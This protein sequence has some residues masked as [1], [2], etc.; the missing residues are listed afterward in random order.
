MHASGSILG[1][2]G[3]VLLHFIWQGALVAALVAAGLWL[4][5]GRGAHERYALACGGL[6][7]MVAAPLVTAA[8]LVGPMLTAPA[9]PA[10][11]GGGPGVPAASPLEAALPLITTLWLVGTIGFQA[12]LLLLWGRAERLRRAGTGPIPATLAPIVADLVARIGVRRPVRVVQSSL[13]MVPTVV[14]WLRPVVLVPAAALTGLGPDQLR[15]VIA[16]ELAH[17]RRHDYLVNVLQ[18]VCEALLFYH[19]AVWWISG[20]IRA[21]REYCC[22]DVAVAVCGNA[23]L[24]ARAL[25]TLDEWRSTD[26]WPALAST[27]EPLMKRICR[28][29]GVRDARSR[30]PVSLMATVTLVMSAAAVAAV[31]SLHPADE[32]DH[33]PPAVAGDPLEGIDVVRIAVAMAAEDAETFELLRDLGL[34]NA[35]L[36]RV[37]KALGTDEKVFRAVHHLAK[38]RARVKAEVMK[39]H[40]ELALQVAEGTMSRAELEEKVKHLTERARRHMAEVQK[41]LVA[42]HAVDEASGPVAHLRQ[43]AVELEAAGQRLQAMHA[44]VARALEAGEISPEQARQH[45]AEI[46]QKRADLAAAH[47]KLQLEREKLHDHV[48]EL[49]D[50]GLTDEEIHEALARETR[51]RP[52]RKLEE[53]RLALEEKLATLHVRADT[54]RADIH[55]ALRAGK[56]DEAEARQKMER[57]EAEIEHAR[58]A[59]EQGLAE[60]AAAAKKIESMR[61]KGLT[62]QEIHEK[63]MKEHA[64]DDAT[65]ARLEALHARAT[66][67]HERIKQAVASGEMTEREAEQKVAALMERVHAAMRKMKMDAAPAKAPDDRRM[68]ALRVRLVDAQRKMERDLAAGTL[69][70]EEIEERRAALQYLEQQ[71]HEREGDHAREHGHDHDGDH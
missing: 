46:D 21:E 18:S 67:A 16:H 70:A 40:D 54:A 53:H 11:G 17:V 42:T 59:T 41:K 61:V 38:E 60:A 44:R 30:R 32:A 22:D 13:V 14:G 24:Y 8:A 65:K 39:V 56:I 3:W 45:M 1:L 51:V 29:V 12:R 58:R 64:A 66:V 6:I 55:A 57:L 49:R 19:P 68:E 48:S 7:A 37:M 69:T 31:G 4:L 26:C 52:D 50:R 35:S 10:G 33:G 25:S 34:D 2:I 28:L 5:R 63:L 62:E 20:R 71:L 43:K 9:L 47:E 36:L 27:G 15:A 23:V